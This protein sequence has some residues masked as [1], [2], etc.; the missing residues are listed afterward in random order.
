MYVPSR[1]D[2][3]IKEK[4][5]NNAQGAQMEGA[6]MDPQNARLA[7]KTLQNYDSWFKREHKK[8]MY[9]SMYLPAAN[10]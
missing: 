6:Q 9:S 5:K 1:C 7:H 8:Y 3:L 4:N 10:L 2:R